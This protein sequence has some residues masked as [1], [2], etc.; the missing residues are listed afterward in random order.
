MDAWLSSVGEMSIF[1]SRIKRIYNFLVFSLFFFKFWGWDLFVVF[2]IDPW[3]M[4]NV[5]MFYKDTRVILCSWLSIMC[6]SEDFVWLKVVH[7]QFSLILSLDSNTFCREIITRLNMF[8]HLVCLE[9][10][11]G[12][13]HWKQIKLTVLKGE[14]LSKETKP[15]IHATVFH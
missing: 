7:L 4:S 13:R 3:C 9:L 5:C 2:V 10:H 6:R 1:Y 12:F 8:T 11:S 14:E 15:A